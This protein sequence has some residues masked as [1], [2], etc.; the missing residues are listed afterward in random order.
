MI[1][2]KETSTKTGLL[3]LGSVAAGLITGNS[4]LVQVTIGDNGA[5]IG[6]LIPTIAAA[7][8]GL[9]DTVRKEQG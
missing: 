3:L 7:L 4:E 5:Q 8:I 6:G 9:F 1:N 2:L